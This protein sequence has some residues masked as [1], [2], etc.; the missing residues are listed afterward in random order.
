MK[1][2]SSTACYRTRLPAAVLLLAAAGLSGCG[3]SS[4]SSPSPTAEKISYEVSVSNATNNQPVSPLAIIVHDDSYSAWTIGETAL[5]ELEY[6]A[7]GGSNS[8]LI[9]SMKSEGAMAKSG[10]GAFGPGGNETISITASDASQTRITVLGML[11]NTIDGFSGI[12][13]VDVSSLA[14]GES[15]TIMASAY[16]AGTEVNSE[17]S[18]TMPGP[19][20]GGEGFNAACSDNNDIVSYRSGVVTADDGLSTSVLDQ[21]H[22]FDN[23]VMLVTITRL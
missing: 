19:D 11:V 15:M 4:S 22:R 17:S 12:N 7:E 8:Q 23:P 1:N 13:S 18:G 20:D 9:D 3:S 21:S 10:K 16:D 2:L 5:T 6:I 14:R